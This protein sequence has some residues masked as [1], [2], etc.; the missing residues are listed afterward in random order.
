MVNKGKGKDHDVKKTNTGKGGVH[1]KGHEEEL[2]VQKSSQGKVKN[3]EKHTHSKKGSH[4]KDTEDEDMKRLVPAI[5]NGSKHQ[6]P[7]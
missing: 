1:K 2:Q 3:N 7:F 4:D 5:T 6:V